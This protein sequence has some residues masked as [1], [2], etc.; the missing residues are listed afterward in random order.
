MEDK[1]KAFKGIKFLKVGQ[2]FL[3]A[4]LR[5]NSSK[6]LSIN[7]NLPIVNNNNSSVKSSVNSVSKS[8]IKSSG[9]YVSTSLIKN[10]GKYVSKSLVKSSFSNEHSI[11]I[12]KRNK[13]KK[14]WS[15]FKEIEILKQLIEIKKEEENISKQNPNIDVKSRSQK[16]INQ[17][18][19][20]KN[21]KQLKNKIIA[22]K[23]III[24]NINNTEKNDNDEN[25]INKDNKKKESNNNNKYENENNIVVYKT[26]NIV[27]KEEVKAE[28]KRKFFCCL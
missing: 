26:E 28:K 13:S 21:F 8:L 5:K 10:S 16:L 6:A 22:F 2:Q 7:G 15:K 17:S 11:N 12:S 3:G 20:S 25:T 1:P 4:Q 24:N 23:S 9:K 19:S 27:K 14:K 18:L